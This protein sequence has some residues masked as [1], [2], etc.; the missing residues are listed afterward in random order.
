MFTQAMPFYCASD[1]GN[2]RVAGLTPALQ[3]SKISIDLWIKVMKMEVYGVI[4]SLV[5]KGQGSTGS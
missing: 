5:R 1:L 4:A 3:T 2:K